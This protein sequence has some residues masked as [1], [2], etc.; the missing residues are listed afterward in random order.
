MAIP[1]QP[2]V[3]HRDGDKV[4]MGLAEKKETAEQLRTELSAL[5][6]EREDLLHGGSADLHEQQ[7]DGE[8]ERLE[9]EVEM[10]RAQRDAANTGGS[11][12]DALEAMR[13]AAA[14]QKEDGTVDLATPLE[15]P[16]QDSTTSPDVVSVP[17]QAD[18]LPILFAAP[19]PLGEPTTDAPKADGE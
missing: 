8:I 14:S 3:L 6:V 18:E 19:L 17:E 7:L 2:G 4:A 12:D 5:R 9:H 13:A 15:V 1:E 11:V 10:A 16:I